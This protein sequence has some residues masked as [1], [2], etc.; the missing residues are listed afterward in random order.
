MLRILEKKKFFSSPCIHFPWGLFVYLTYSQYYVI[1]TIN[2]ILSIS[3][4]SS[5]WVKLWINTWGC[6]SCGGGGDGGNYHE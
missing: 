3:L 1:L 5:G 6:Y 4:S 2:K